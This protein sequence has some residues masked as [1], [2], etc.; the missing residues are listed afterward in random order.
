MELV[1]DAS[2]HIKQQIKRKQV[3]ARR[4]TRNHAQAKA[5][6]IIAT[7]RNQAEREGR[8]KKRRLQ[9]RA[10][11][12]AEHKYHKERNELR[13][14]I[15]EAKSELRTQLKE[16]VWAKLD[17]RLTEEGVTAHLSDRLERVLDENAEDKEDFTIKVTGDRLKDRKIVASTDIKTYRVTLEDI[18]SDKIEAYWSDHLS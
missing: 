15:G 8:D 1:H 11:T 18:V 10:D 17:N 9:D 14:Q 2:D 5:K 12:V 13:E 3:K 16:A 6:K 4:Q 7:K